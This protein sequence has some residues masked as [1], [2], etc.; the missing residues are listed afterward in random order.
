M[1][2]KIKFNTQQLEAS[3][4]QAGEASLANGARSLRR[5]AERVRDLAQDNAPVDDGDLEAAIE[6]QESVDDRR[7]KQFVVTIDTDRYSNVSAEGDLNQQVGDYAALM[8]Q[9]TYN[10]GPG[11]Q[12]KAA[13]GKK[14]GNRFMRRAFLE[15]TKRAFED[16]AAAVKVTLGRGAR[17]GT[18]TTP[19]R[20]SRDYSG[21]DE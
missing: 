11:S 21:S 5:V 6:V 3:I 4:R 18:S 1:G 16:I 8:E 15:G 2:V 20:T 17:L 12:E 7:R 19:L 13:T 14:V 10:L 9:G